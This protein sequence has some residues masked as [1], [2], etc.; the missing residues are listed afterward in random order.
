MKEN[1][2]SPAVSAPESIAGG[3]RPS[4]I[5]EPDIPKQAAGT[6][7]NQKWKSNSEGDQ[8]EKYVHYYDSASCEA[9]EMGDLAA[10]WLLH[11]A[12][13]VLISSL[14]QSDRKVEF[15]GWAFV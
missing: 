14:V 2:D 4:R 11:K 7:P 8:R 1:T 9:I 3:V 15:L 12:A 6:P 13:G 5:D 10:R